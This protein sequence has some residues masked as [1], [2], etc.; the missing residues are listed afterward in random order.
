MKNLTII[1]TYMFL[2]DLYS[3]YCQNKIRKFAQRVAEKRLNSELVFNF[4]CYFVRYLPRW[5]FKATMELV[6]GYADNGNLDIIDRA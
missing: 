3:F 4:N 2:K 5:N 1:I 6:S